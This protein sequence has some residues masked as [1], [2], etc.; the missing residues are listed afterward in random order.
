MEYHFCTFEDS[1]KT[2]GMT[3]NNN[4]SELGQTTLK[5]RL[6]NLGLDIINLISINLD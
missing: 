3:N 5:F 6:V 2:M 1:V 4:E